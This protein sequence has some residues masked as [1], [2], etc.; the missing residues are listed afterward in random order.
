ML[1]IYESHL[2]MGKNKVFLILGSE[3][4]YLI[5]FFESYLQFKGFYPLVVKKSKDLLKLNNTYRY[6]AIIFVNSNILEYQNVNEIK[7]MFNSLET[8]LTAY[9][10]ISL[11]KVGSWIKAFRSTCMC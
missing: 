11:I 9:Y 5:D 2:N 10:G 1:D 7:N 6:D 3:H 4:R 8:T